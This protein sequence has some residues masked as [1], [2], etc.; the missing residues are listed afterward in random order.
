MLSPTIETERLVLRRYKESD[1]DAIY[2]I[3]TDERLTNYITYPP[4]TKEQELDCIKKW[5]EEADINKKEKWVMEL[6]TTKEIVVNIDVNTVV[7]KHN[8][9]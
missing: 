2:E 3:I 9:R 7:E 6:K 8:F 4:Y 5:I 1:I